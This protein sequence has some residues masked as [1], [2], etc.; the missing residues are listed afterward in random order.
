MG[1]EA[2]KAARYSLTLLH[3]MSYDELYNYHQDFGGGLLLPLSA[4]IGSWLCTPKAA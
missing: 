1:R 4:A 3:R 2:M